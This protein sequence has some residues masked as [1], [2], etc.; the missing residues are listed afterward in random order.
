MS[1][2]WDIVQEMADKKAVKYAKDFPKAMPESAYLA[3]YM[4]C[5][6]ERESLRVINE[7]LRKRLKDTEQDVVAVAKMYAAAPLPVPNLVGCAV[8]K[9]PPPILGSFM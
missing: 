5:A 9:T 7:E 4:E 3:G 1:I 6:G 2:N 8:P